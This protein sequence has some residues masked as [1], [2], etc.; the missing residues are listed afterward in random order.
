MSAFDRSGR[1]QVELPEILTDIASP[2]VP[3]YVDDLLAQTAATR[4]RPRWT[5][6]ERWLPMGVIARRSL[7]FPTVPWRTLVTVAVLIALLAVALFAAGS[8]TRV[9]PPFGPA[10]NGALVFGGG[11]IYLRDGLTGSTKLVVGGPTDDFAAGFTRDGTR[12]TFLRRTQGLAGSFNELLQMMAAKPDGSGAI[13]ISEPLVAPDWSDLA[14]DDSFV[15]VATGDPSVG[16]V[17]E[18]VDLRTT[19]PMRQIDVGDPQMKFLVPNFLGPN[20]TEIVFRGNTKT[21]VGRRSG[22]FAV[23]PDGSGLRT[24]TPTDGFDGDYLFPQPSPDGHFIA[25]TT[26]DGEAKLN[27]M[28]IL[29]LRAGTDRVVSDPARSQGFASFSPDSQRILFLTYGTDRTQVTVAPVD[30]SRPIAMGPNYPN[31]E[32][33]SVTGVFSPD[34]KS[35]LVNDSGSKETRLVDAATGGNGELLPWSAGNVSGWQRLAP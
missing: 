9:P 24:L 28:H 20:G 14:P 32:N 31:V 1:F 19:G 2:R 25:Y 16:Q 17:L 30:G 34:G 23:H 13:A 33:E 21:S 11:D 6:L 12:L 7:F 4:Q 22:L 27:R 5:F 10:R 29:D 3:D 8:H 18:I 26:W 15:V 35:V